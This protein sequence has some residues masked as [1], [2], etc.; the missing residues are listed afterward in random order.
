MQF[1]YRNFAREIHS[2]IESMKG[3]PLVWHN[4]KKPEGQF[5]GSFPKNN[6]DKTNFVF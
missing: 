4:W 1:S 2:Y 5:P 3:G 6:T